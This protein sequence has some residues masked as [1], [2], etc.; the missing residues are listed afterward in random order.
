MKSFVGR[1]QTFFQHCHYTCRW[2]DKIGEEKTCQNTIDEKNDFLDIEFEFI[3]ADVMD[4]HVLKLL[5]EW[6]NDTSSQYLNLFF[7]QNDTEANFRSSHRLPT[8]LYMQNVPIWVYAESD[9]SSKV[10]SHQRFETIRCFGGSDISIEDDATELKWAKCVNDAYNKYVKENL[11]EGEPTK[12]EALK[13]CDRWS[14]VYNAL[15]LPFKLRSIGVE[16]DGSRIADDNLSPEIENL[17]GEVEHNRWNAE[18]LLLGFRP[19][20]SEES[21]DKGKFIHKDIR[22]NA[23]LSEKTKDKDRKL[24]KDLIKEINKTNDNVFADVLDSPVAQ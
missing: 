16:Y 23:Q 4:Y 13:I 6:S 3:E 17:L 2:W 15:S 5:K 24:L 7:C 8:E 19:P 21:P 14:N 18:K 1:H 20:V 10:L 12:W 22:P 11:K 9:S